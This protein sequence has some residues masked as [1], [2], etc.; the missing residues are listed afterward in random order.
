MGKS[1]KYSLE[2]LISINGD[3]KEAEG[4]RKYF[5]DSKNNRIRTLGVFVESPDGYELIRCSRCME[6]V[7]VEKGTWALDMEMCEPCYC[8]HQGG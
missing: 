2:D 4:L 5:K 6:D 1:M 3:E 7:L 8:Q